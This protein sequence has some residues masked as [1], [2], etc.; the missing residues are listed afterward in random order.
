MSLGVATGLFDFYRHGRDALTLPK[1]DS[2]YGSKPHSRCALKGL[3]QH[4]EVQ[5][6]MVSG[7]LSGDSGSYS[8][9]A[10]LLVTVN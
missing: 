2:C 1:D 6:P 7:E 4:P 8:E 3:I 9:E 5:L 10:R